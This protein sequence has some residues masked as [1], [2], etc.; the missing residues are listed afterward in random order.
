MKR[1]LAL[2]L[3][4]CLSACTLGP[5]YKPP[6]V[7][8]SATG[9]FVSAANPAVSA[10]PLPDGW[11]KLYQDPRL[12]AL[13][14]QAFAANDDIR[15]AEANLAA[16]RA[17]FEGAR[18]LQLPQTTAS[19]GAVYG[20]DVT[21]DTV[22]ELTDRE[23]QDTWLFD[24]TFDMAYEVDLFGQVR[25][26]VEAARDNAQ[27]VD[28]VL[29]GLRVTIAA[30]VA[31]AYG[32]V[33]ALGEERAVA[34]RSLAITADQLRIVQASEDAG[35]STDFDV[36]RSKTLVAQVQASIPP[37]DGARRAAVFELSA[38]LGKTPT[39]APFN[40]ES[41]V[42]PPRLAAPLP[43]GDGAALLR[44]RPDIRAADRKLATALAEIGVAKADLFPK[45][46]LTGFYGGAAT[47]FNLLGSNSGLTWGLGPA[48][49]WTFPNIAGPLAKL[50]Q[51]RASARG[52]LA[53][54]DQTVLTALKETE[55]ALTTYE[56]ELAH[57]AALADA[58]ADASHALA[59]AQAQ[60]TAGQ[61]SNLD[62]LTSEQTQVTT[63]AAVASSDAAL[64]QDQIALFKAL[65]GGWQAELR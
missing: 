28:A 37:L 65:G 64:I 1:R 21:V 58:A 18:A 3:L 56:A 43:V 41:C 54:F 53:S 51:T 16:S 33:C 62:L 14:L 15:V 52:A 10:D 24:A 4:A 9:G 5:D 50:A 46:S 11:W 39:E 26:E 40:V 6:A 2:G 13:I 29:D 17:L 22:L 55:Q 34:E 31:R 23:P 48:I 63:A 59:L 61:I 38:L 27:S 20:R 7:P 35:A 44:R 25:R 57:H 42:T 12:D 8:P 36:A 49:S 32:S 47:Q 45:V 19:A 30:E 60:F